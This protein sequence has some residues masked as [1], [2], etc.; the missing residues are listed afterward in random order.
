M[1]ITAR[2]VER[3]LAR[4]EQHLGIC[5]PERKFVTVVLD[6]QAER[7]AHVKQYTYEDQTQHGLK[8]GD[9]VYA[10]VG[11]Y[12]VSKAGTVI[13]KGAT[14]PSYFPVKSVGDASRI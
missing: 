11:N 14:V 5:E 13:R 2:E 8:P 12:G 1:A 9:R 4:I 6:E 10:P 3:R 7:S